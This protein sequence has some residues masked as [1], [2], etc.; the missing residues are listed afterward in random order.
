MKILIAEDDL[1]PRMILKTAVEQFGHEC[2]VAEEGNAAWEIFQHNQVN[3]IISDR[4]MPGMD[5]IELCRRVRE[6][7]SDSY[8]YFIFITSLGEREHLLDGINAGA[9]DYLPKPFNPDDLRIRLQVAAR[10]TSLHRQLS[11][12]KSELE[13]LNL[14]LYEQGRRDP[15]T[16]LGNRLRLMEDL[17]ILMGQAERYGHQYAALMCDVDFFKSYNDH[18]GHLAGDEVL[19]SLSQ[20]IFRTGRSGDTAYRYGGEEFLIVLPEQS[21]KQ[22]L[23]VAERLRKGVETMAIPHLAKDP[24]GVITLSIG[25]AM[26]NPGDPRPTHLWIKRADDALYRA[27]QAGRNRIEL[28]AEPS[29]S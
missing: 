9:D 1:I 4:I 21:P 8:T 25:V 23:V 10:I 7:V 18:Y 12:Q 13:R 6:A 19:R 2:L 5:G 24:P 22:A 16:S 3:V 20:I 14:E 17:P 27:K 26:L 28:S 15:L 29:S 11:Q